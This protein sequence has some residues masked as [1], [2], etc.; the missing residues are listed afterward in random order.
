MTFNSFTYWICLAAVQSL[1]RFVQKIK[2][3]CNRLLLVRGLFQVINSWRLF[4]PRLITLWKLCCSLVFHE[5]GR[6]MKAWKLVS[7]FYIVLS[8]QIITLVMMFNMI[9]LSADCPIVELAMRKFGLKWR[10][11]EFL[12][13][14]QST[15]STTLLYKTTWT[16]IYLSV[17]CII[18]SSHKSSTTNKSSQSDW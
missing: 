6:K 12:L 11:M 7:K 2:Y 18:T 5:W 9:W 10:T 1:F 14:E 8:S 15:R 3:F 17:K 13:W 16:W 4:W